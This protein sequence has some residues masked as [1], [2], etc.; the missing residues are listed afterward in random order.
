MIYIILQRRKILV[1]TFLI[2]IVSIVIMVISNG[3][4]QAASA[5]YANNILT[6]KLVTHNTGNM[7]KISGA[8]VELE[9]FS[10]DAAGAQ[11]SAE[12]Y[13]PAPYELVHWA[14]GASINQSFAT[15]RDVRQSCFWS[16]PYASG[17]PGSLRIT[18]KV[19]Y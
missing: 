7:S 1:T 10:A 8:F 2:S 6:P 9:P 16:Y 14:T 12:T 17:N 4:A 13:R 18:C 19:R 15:A 3:I 11:V 5:T